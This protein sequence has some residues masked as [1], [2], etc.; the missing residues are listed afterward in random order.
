[1]VSLTKTTKSI[2]A[3]DITRNWHLIDAQGKVVGRIATEIAQLLMGKQ[4]KT[5]VEYL[6]CGDNVVVINA[7]NVVLTGMKATKKGY[8][9]YSGYP[10]GLTKVSFE[11]MNKKRPGE[12]IRHAV[13]GMLPK[14]KHRDPR[15]ARLHVYKDA[16]HLYVNKFENKTQA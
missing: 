13:S 4:K 14:N 10:G 3:D 7:Q 1:M 2:K 16:N 8:A 9:R 11:D 5:H 6:D 15:L 12:V